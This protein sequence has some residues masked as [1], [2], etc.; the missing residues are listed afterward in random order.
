VRS[1]RVPDVLT[2]AAVL[3]PSG[4][5]TLGEATVWGSY[6]LDAITNLML[7]FGWFSESQSTSVTAGVELRIGRFRVRPAWR[8]RDAG[9][10]SRVITTF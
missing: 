2:E 6:N 4:R 1:R 7:G 8:L 3:F 9:F 10:D 5:A